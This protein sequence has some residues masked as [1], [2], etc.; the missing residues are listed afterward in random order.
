M[1]LA[2]AALVC[3]PDSGKNRP[4]SSSRQ[5][6]WPNHACRPSSSTTAMGPAA[7]SASAAFGGGAQRP[8]DLPHPALADPDQPGDVGEGEALAALGLPQPP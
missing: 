3:S 6:A 1:A 8:Q 7:R 4:G 2:S 5:A